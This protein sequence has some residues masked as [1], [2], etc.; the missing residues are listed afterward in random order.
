MTVLPLG[1]AKHRGWVPR[2]EEESPVGLDQLPSLLV[3]RNSRPSERCP[4]RSPRGADDDLGPHEYWI[5]ASSH[6]LQAPISSGSACREIRFAPCPRWVNLKCFTALVDGH[7]VAAGCRRRQS[8]SSSSLPA[9]PT[10][11]LPSR[12]SAI[13]GDL[14]DSIDAACRPPSPN[15]ACARL[16]VQRGN[17]GTSGSPRRD[18][19]VI[20]G[21]RARLGQVVGR[22]PTWP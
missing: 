17:R 9:G 14:A 4:A 3:I 10:N 5:S 18:I 8:A 15:T 20:A 1:C 13:A 2:R 12:S 7:V 22:R 16:Q 11:G 21:G 6:G 19:S